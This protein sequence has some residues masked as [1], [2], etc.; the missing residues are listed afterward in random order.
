MSDSERRHDDECIE[1]I[2]CSAYQTIL[3]SFGGRRDWWYVKG[4]LSYISRVYHTTFHK[5][6]RCELMKESSLFVED[7]ME[8]K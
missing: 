6:V 2:Q 1:P 4:E 3:S 8:N 5:D 7:L